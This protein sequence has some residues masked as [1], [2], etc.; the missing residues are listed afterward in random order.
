[1]QKTLIILFLLA[2]APSFSAARILFPS[3]N[4]D[5]DK[6]FIYAEGGIIRG[7]TDKKE[8]AI[9]FTGDEFA[10]G[11]GHIRNVLNKMEI[12]STFFLTGNFYRNENFK[13]LIYRLK[14]DGHYL[15]A[16]SDKHLLYCTW[17]D[18]DSLLVSF[19]QFK[20]DLLDNYSE[21]EKFDIKNEDAIYFMPPYEWYN[22]NISK[23][24][25]KLGFTLVNF[26]PGTR[27]NADYTTPSMGD[28]Y[29]S[30]QD[31]FNK[32]IEYEESDP[33]GLNGF[34]LLVHI[35]TSPER[36]DKFYYKL[37]DLITE[38]T[39]RGYSFKRIDELLN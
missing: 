17:E 21:M 19:D 28:R 23:W 7:E 39:S 2:F 32:I 3:D 1:V 20:S 11:G 6:N 26:T 37:E 30:S 13:E 15:G 5:P 10:D 22:N 9:V 24:T 34:I 8:L 33:N 29:I 4:I 36:E 27:S 25:K 38:L 14:E 31:I 35:G 18:R 16:H 12:K